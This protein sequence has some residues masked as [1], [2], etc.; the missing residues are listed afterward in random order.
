M[1]SASLANAFLPSFQVMEIWQK[2]ASLKYPILV[3][4]AIVSIVNSLDQKL[5]DYASQFVEAFELVQ[6]L[7]IAERGFYGRR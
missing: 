4:L 3:L 2:V 1:A 7:N 5:V 6:Y